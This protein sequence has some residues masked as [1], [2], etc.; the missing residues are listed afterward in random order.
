M[1]NRNYKVLQD[2]REQN[3]WDF[4][5][6]GIEKT[7]KKLDTGDYTL[8]GYEDKLCIERKYSTGE[9]SVNLGSKSKQF[10]AEINRMLD[11]EYRYLI[12][13]FSHDTM[14]RFPKDSGIPQK[15]HGK[16]RMNANFITSCL[17]RIQNDY[18]IEVIFAGDKTNAIEQVISIFDMV[19]TNG[20][21][22]PVF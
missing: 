9:L 20:D 3:P 22:R 12:L 11:F 16:L 6:Y 21:R 10:W 15:T 2:T 7:I 13:E 8:V 18:G 19:T 14:R 1:E 17:D 5:F 4:S